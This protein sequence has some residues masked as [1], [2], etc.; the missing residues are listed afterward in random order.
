MQHSGQLVTAGTSTSPAWYK[1][2]CC[3]SGAWANLS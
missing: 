1:A 2:G 3:S